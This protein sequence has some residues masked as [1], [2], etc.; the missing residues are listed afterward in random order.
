[1]LASGNVAFGAQEGNT[2]SLA[3][4]LGEKIKTVFSLDVS[5][6]ARSLAEVKSMVDANPFADIVVT[7]QTRLY[8]TF[9]AENSQS[10]LKIPYE[11]PQNGFT[12]LSVSDSEVCSVLTLTPQSGTIQAMDILEKEFG[13][14]T[15]ARRWYTISRMAQTQGKVA[16]EQT[17]GRT[18]VGPYP[19]LGRPVIK[20]PASGTVPG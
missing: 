14:S 4:T 12:I 7:K 17:Q 6:I 18:A 11:S 16:G 19:I 13:K 10:S 2:G 8:V 1:M 3:Q 15:T 5:V 20:S 9:L